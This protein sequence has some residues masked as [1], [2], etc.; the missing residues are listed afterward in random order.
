[1]NSTGRTGG[2]ASEFQAARNIARQQLL[3]EEEMDSLSP[4][5]RFKRKRCRMG[6]ASISEF[7]ERN[8][9]LV[10]SAAQLGIHRISD[11]GF[12]LVWFGLI[13]I[14]KQHESY[15]GM[16]LVILNHGQMTKTTPE[17]AHPSPNF[18]ATPTAGRLATTYPDSKESLKGFGNLVVGKGK[19]LTQRFP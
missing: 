2:D 13:P 10:C 7:Y 8:L 9:K 16:D 12:G 17:L 11:S 4:A 14:L 1:M 18:H 19:G 5:F 6:K 15:F 3:G